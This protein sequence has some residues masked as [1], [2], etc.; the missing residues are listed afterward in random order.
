MSPTVL[1][2][3]NARTVDCFSKPGAYITNNVMSPLSD[4]AGGNLL[5]YMQLPLEPLLFSH[6]L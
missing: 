6:R 5:D 4:P 1:Y 2:E 3:C